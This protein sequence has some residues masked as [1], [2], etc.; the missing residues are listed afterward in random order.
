L[1]LS[2]IAIGALRVRGNGA[3]SAVMSAPAWR[4]VLAATALMA[5]V[6]GTR[7]AFGLFISP[8]NSATGIGLA[9]LGFAIA[10]GQLAQGVA[11]P[12][13][14]WL[15][16]R[17]GTARVMI[18][19]GWGLAIATLALTVVD[20]V[21]SMTL[22]AIAVA[23]AGSAVGSNSLL[24]AE[25]GRR[26]SIEQRAMAFA[27]VSAGGS[28]GQMLIAPATQAAI[29]GVGWILAIALT[30][31]VG[32]LALPLARAFAQRNAPAMRREPASAPA[33]VQDVLR[34]PT[35]WF[36]ALSFG[37]CGFHVA[38][39]TTHMPGVIERCGLSPSLAGVWLAVLG[40]ANIA[41]SLA[42][43]VLL[44]RISTQA[45]LIGV[46]TL[47]AASIVLLLALPVSP[48]VML[49][50]AIMM[51]LSYM[52]LLPAISQQV[53]ERYGTG[54]L[55]TIFGVV[56]LVHQIGSFAGAW[57]GGVVAEAT[58]RDTL[59]WSI[60]IGLAL[61]AIAFQVRLGAAR[62]KRAVTVARLQAA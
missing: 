2:I 27:V 47:R 24:L 60:D 52:A 16:D 36:I 26:V 40:V 28:A 17:Y 41:G 55:A 51:G 12:P 59:T 14:G 21:A 1:F 9:G 42:A 6:M 3:W 11:Q 30:A 13:L 37:V 54:R 62:V 5:L 48:L 58:G 44:R 53:A 10:V 20:S 4:C 46:F 39:L 49:G 57:L 33:A 32:L 22:V 31:G 7:S 18:I 35:F 25:V 19:G 23:V 61:L 29:D 45:F 50:F 43:G 34:E 8:M 56:A 15:A 38:F